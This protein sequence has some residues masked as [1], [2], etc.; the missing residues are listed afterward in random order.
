MSSMVGLLQEN[1]PC[2]V[3]NDSNSTYLNPWSFNND[4]NMLYM[5]QPNQ[6]GFSWDFLKNGTL[7]H[8]VGPWGVPITPDNFTSGVPQTNS[9]YSVG[10][11]PSQLMANAAN[12]TQNAARALWHLAQTWFQEFPEYKPDDHAISVF[13]DWYG[14]R[15]GPAFAAFFEEQNHRIADKST[16]EKG[17]ASPIHL[18]TLGIFN[19][20]IDL[21]T[22]ESAYLTMAEN[23]TY[24]IRTFNETD[25]LGDD[26]YESEE[27]LF[28]N[29][30]KEVNNPHDSC[31]AVASR[32]RDLA[33]EGDPYFTL[34]NDTVNSACSDAARNCGFEADVLESL[35]DARSSYDIAAI[36]PDPFPPKYFIGYLA[37][38]HVQ[39]ALGVPV[40]FTRFN[41]DIT[42]G[43][44]LKSGEYETADARGGYL[45]DLGNLLDSG[46]K[47]ALIYGDRDWSRN[48]FGG[49]RV[50][51]ALNHTDSGAFQ[52]AGYVNISTNSSYVG[53]QV[54][55]FGSLSFSRVFQ[56]GRQVAA[57]QP[58]TAYQIFRRA[59]FGKDIATGTFD[60]SGGAYY[61]TAGP[62][63]TF[64][65]K[66]VDPGSPSPQCYVW[67]MP[68]TC[69]D[70]QMESVLNGSGLVHNYI[71]IDAT[72]SHLFPR[73]GN[74]DIVRPSGSQIKPEMVRSS[75]EQDGAE[76]VTG[77]GMVVGIVAVLLG[78]WMLIW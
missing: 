62:A 12:T 23:N 63:T 4:V 64:Q 67:D 13:T 41:P 59:V 77:R 70:E 65:V 29:L 60:M 53:G 43:N 56:A 2:M 50:S 22:Q 6:V 14:G 42:R 28:R 76:V 18:H 57:Y 52:A 66:N 10:T 49:E 20:F 51:L 73:I 55:Q 46:V 45:K 38:A 40:N 3:N 54:R 48:W 26:E 74:N 16:N 69:T 30:T 9:S 61:T 71:L 7:D 44:F 17:E 32:C 1:G 11:F 47:I 37:N 21:A 78:A 72:Q 58:E 34:T 36:D 15:Y 24:G 39:A 68:N 31:H 75:A 25:W 19:G 5:D 27:T 35:G 33:A 8:T